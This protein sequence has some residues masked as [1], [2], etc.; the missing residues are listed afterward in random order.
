MAILARTTTACT[1][2]F[3]RESASFFIAAQRGRLR[4]RPAR[5]VSAALIPPGAVVVPDCQYAPYANHALDSVQPRY[6]A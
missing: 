2:S 5:P 3:D 6:A 1:I 4:A